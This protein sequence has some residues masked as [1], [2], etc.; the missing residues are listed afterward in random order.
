MLDFLLVRNQYSKVAYMKT[1]K[2]QRFAE[3]Y[4]KNPDFSSQEF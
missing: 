4:G 1:A 2:Y 3:I